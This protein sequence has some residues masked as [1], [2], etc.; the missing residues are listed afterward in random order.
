MMT[1]NVLYFGM[2]AE[3]TQKNSEEFTFKNQISVQE[4]KDQLLEKYSALQKMSFQVAV[5]QKL[6][7]AKTIIENNNEI[8]ILPPFAGG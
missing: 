4:L 1:C 2:I 7:S 5:N 6:T 3:S 8:A